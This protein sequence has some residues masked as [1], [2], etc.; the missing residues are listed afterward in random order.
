MLPYRSPAQLRNLCTGLVALALQSH[1]RKY[2]RSLLMGLQPELKSRGHLLPQVLSGVHT[3][4]HKKSFGKQRFI[5]K[6]IGG[7]RDGFKDNLLDPELLEL[8]ILRSKE[9]IFTE[10]REF[11]AQIDEAIELSQGLGLAAGFHSVG[12]FILE[13]WGNLIPTDTPMEPIELM[14]VGS[15]E[16]PAPKQ[17]GGAVHCFD[18]TQRWWRMMCTALLYPDGDHPSYEK[19]AWM[20]DDV[21]KPIGQI[22]PSSP[23]GQMF[24][25]WR[26]WY[27]P[28]I[29]WMREKE[30]NSTL[31]N[32]LVD[33]KQTRSLLAFQVHLFQP[34]NILYMGSDEVGFALLQRALS[35]VAWKGDI[36]RTPHA[37]ASVLY[38]EGALALRQL[39]AKLPPIDGT[40]DFND[41]HTG[42]SQWSDTAELN[43]SSN[44]SDTSNY[45]R[46]VDKTLPSDSY[47]SELEGVDSESDNTALLDNRQQDDKNNSHSELSSEDYSHQNSLEPSLSYSDHTGSFA[48]VSMEEYTSSH[49]NFTKKYNEFLSETPHDSFFYKRLS[50]SY[51][52]GLILACGLFSAGALLGMLV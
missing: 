33:D 43:G 38:K 17:G 20:I 5:N 9:D 29:P 28:A 45:R 22:D 6:M 19:I 37:S 14:I 48:E 35:R 25:K 26:I 8:Q 27:T 2:S 42:E 13:L 30:S 46:D 12:D 18:D 15:E 21:N 10:L 11:R 52:E 49:S 24:R 44:Y 3:S 31:P 39:R 34:K 40:I 36:F 32:E 1:Q 41:E 16:T 50:V 23:V 7:Y 51:L 47:F 4:W